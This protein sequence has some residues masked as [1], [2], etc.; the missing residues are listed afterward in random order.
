MIASCP[1]GTTFQLT[2]TAATQY[3]RT[4]AC[5]GA[6]AAAQRTATAASASA[7][8]RPTSSARPQPPLHPRVDRTEVVEG[9]ALGGAHVHLHRLLRVEDHGV[10]RLVDP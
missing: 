3:R 10:A 5:A 4:L 8:R 6:A 9:R 1:F 7:A 2:G